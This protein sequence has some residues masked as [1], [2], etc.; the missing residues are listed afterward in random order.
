M[1]DHQ[2]DADEAARL[3]EAPLLR[4]AFQELEANIVARLASPT[5]A[6]EQIIATQ[7][8]LVAHRRVE[9]WLKQLVITGQMDAIAAE[10]KKPRAT[11][12]RKLL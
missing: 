6:P 7:H 8:E 5:L 2:R 9:R 12:K 4:R 10:Q 11:T 1:T 3:L